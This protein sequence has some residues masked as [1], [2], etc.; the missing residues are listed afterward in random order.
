MLVAYVV[1]LVLPSD[2]STLVRLIMSYCETWDVAAAVVLVKRS[3]VF[4]SHA[5]GRGFVC[6]LCSCLLRM[7]PGWQRQKL[8]QKKNGS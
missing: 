6:S 4:F 7:M 8:D 5:A 2:W 1:V 3:A